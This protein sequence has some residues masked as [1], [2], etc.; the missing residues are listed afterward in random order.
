MESIPAKEIKMKELRQAFF[1]MHEELSNAHLVSLLA[2]EYYLD[3]PSQDDIIYDYFNHIRDNLL[4][5]FYMID[6]YVLK[7]M[8]IAKE[9]M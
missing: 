4:R 5:I 1:Y 3:E 7:A 6:D 8:E 9:N 2:T